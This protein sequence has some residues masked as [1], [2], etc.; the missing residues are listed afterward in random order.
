MVGK[1][2]VVRS[3]ARPA[4]TLK[5]TETHDPPQSPHMNNIFRKVFNARRGMIVAVDETKTSAPQRSAAGEGLCFSGARKHATF[6]GSTSG[7]EAVERI[8]L[9]RK[10]IRNDRHCL[11]SKMCKRIASAL[12]MNYR[13]TLKSGNPHIPEIPQ[14]PGILRNLSESDPEVKPGRG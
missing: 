8:L 6:W 13:E 7:V 4:P 14:H 9:D 3:E 10:G 11:T 12:G 5:Q 2:F 1:C